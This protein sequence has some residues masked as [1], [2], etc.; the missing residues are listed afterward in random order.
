MDTTADKSQRE[1]LIHLLRSGKT[2]R[3][4]AEELGKSIPWSYKWQARYKHAGWAGLQE[5]SRAPQRVARQT[6]VHVRKAVLR[7]RSELETEAQKVDTLSYIGAGAIRACL[8]VQGIKPLPSTATIERILHQAGVTKPRT[9][10]SKK[11][12]V[13]PHLCP[14]TTHQLTQIDIVP[15]YLK[16]GTSIACFNGIDVVSRY[17]AGKPYASKSSGDATDFLLHV[18]RELG[19][20]EYLQMDNES[21]FSGGYKHAYVIGK[22]V[23]LALLVGVQPVFSPFYHPKSNAHVERFH[24]DYSA[25]VW[26]KGRMENLSDVRKRSA[27]FFPN[28]RCS[29]H[30][31][32]LAGHSPQEIHP[33]HSF[34]K[35]PAGFRLPVKLPITEG[36][37]HFMR[38]I[39]LEHNALIL[40]TSWTVSLAQPE[41]GVWATLFLT[42]KGAKLR[43][44]DSAPDTLKRHC[45]AE[46]PFPLKEPVV[47]L[48]AQFR[49]SAQKVSWQHILR[50]LFRRPL[51]APST[52]S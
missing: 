22:A 12:V 35:L 33:L 49:S 13:Y 45:L 5:R 19:L 30:H 7:V 48:Q 3:E 9:T 16:G 36:Q 25:F 24:Q 15:H 32:Q 21:C 2:P 1:V 44:Y 51:P 40:N 39:D 43:F 50:S 47:P 41:Q 38:A 10:Q 8:M 52:M 42:Q 46:Y 18:W 34:H 26:K 11:E 31:S 17:P 6:P 14:A 29:H 20:S 23:R 27:L 37:I 28:Y 4:A